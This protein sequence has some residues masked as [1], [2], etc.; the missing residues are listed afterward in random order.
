MS[1]DS[2]RSI[3]I[4]INHYISNAYIKVYWLKNI[5][6]FLGCCLEKA[7]YQL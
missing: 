5:S 6:T 3:T 1:K 4:N 2:V 7:I